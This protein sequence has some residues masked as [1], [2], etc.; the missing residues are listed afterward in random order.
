M[1]SVRV[2]AAIIARDGSVLAARRAD[3][4]HGG[5]EFP[6]GKIEEGE[7][8][9]Q[10]LERELAEE[11]GCEVASAWPYDTVSLEDGGRRL[12]MECFVC[13]LASGAEPALDE[14]VHAELRWLGREELADV[15]WLPADA[16]VARSL[17]CYWDEALVDQQ[18]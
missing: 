2:V 12:T 17:A 4:E 6:G 11:L 14:R 15:E 13:A 3:V 1:T 18:L 8:A 16:L 9:E 7:G 10:A 5:W